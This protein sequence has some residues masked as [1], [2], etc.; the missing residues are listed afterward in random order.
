MEPS[1]EHRRHHNCRQCL[2]FTG[3]LPLLDTGLP[4]SLGVALPYLSGVELSCAREQPL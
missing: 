4:S 2:P 3:G 1:K